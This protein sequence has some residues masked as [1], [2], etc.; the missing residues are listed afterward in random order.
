MRIGSFG[1]SRQNRLGLA[2]CALLLALYAVGA[3]V[4]AGRESPTYDEPYHAVSA[5]VQSNRHDFRIDNEDPP[6]WQYWA[7]LPNGPDALRADFDGALW[8]DMATD[9]SNQW[10][11]M[12]ATLYG[13]PDND[14][15]RLIGRC[16][17]MM[18]VVAVALGGLV[19]G[20]A[21]RLGGPI[22]A[23]A[24]TA[25]FAFDPNFLAHGSLMKNDVAASLAWLALA[26]GLWDVGRRAT[27]GSIGRMAVLAALP[28]TVKYSGVLVAALV[29]A[30]L[31]LRALSGAAWPVFGR[32]V[33]TRRG[34][35][36]A[37]GGITLFTAGV[38]VV[39][40]WAAYG[41]RFRSGPALTDRLDVAMLANRATDHERQ[42]QPG[43]AEPGW[44]VRAATAAERYHL[45]PE[46]FVAGFLFT[47]GE[48]L[49]RP[50]YLLGEV[51]YTGWWYYFP[52]VMLMK[53]P[54][55]TL[56]AAAGT[57]GLA[58]A[59]RR[60]MTGRWAATALAMSVAVYMASAVSTNL[61][62]GL[63]HVL[64]V[65]PPIFIAIGWALATAVRRWGRRAIVGG[66]VLAIG[67]VVE[68]AAAWPH[69]IPFT[70]RPAL[71]WAGGDRR[72]L[73]TDSNLDWGQDLPLLAAWQRAHAGPLYLAYFGLADPRSFGIRYVP[74]PGGYAYDPPPRQFPPVDRAAWVAVSASLLQSTP[75]TDDRFKGYYARLAARK[76]EQV[77]GGSIYVFRAEPMDRY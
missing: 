75:Y 29:P 50:S 13:T 28:I 54:V 24:A 14:A 58:I 12:H 70:N 31:G 34:R 61:N 67:L 57:A 74:L 15:A 22:A 73:F 30:T 2:G 39:A 45:L 10:A 46:P 5:W 4:A 36:V 21:W 42:T 59:W 56:A 26:W 64:P 33:V 9:V 6:L 37:T 49:V 1:V 25:L 18:L 40:I 53:T 19:A 60:G 68:T 35:L 76:P 47:Y 52:L 48:S 62:I 7:S 69:L 63:R 17:A 66:C 41:F 55:A 44:A 3:G 77:L 51:S 32:S 71:A 16:R 27:A 11:W 38:I 43:R 20:W 72:A 8:R 65:Y 23:V